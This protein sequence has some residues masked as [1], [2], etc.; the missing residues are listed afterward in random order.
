LA[1]TQ[2][3]L[4]GNFLSSKGGNHTMAEEMAEHLKTTGYS[5]IT[6]SSQ[7][8]RLFRLLDMVFTSWGRKKEYQVAYVEL[9]SGPAFLWAEAVC[10][11]LSLLKKPYILALHGGNLPIFAQRWPERVKR[12]LCKPTKVVAPSGYLVE[13]MQ[14]W[15]DEIAIIPNPIKVQL[16]PFRSRSRPMPRL[17][18]LRAFHEI[19]C[20]QMAP[21]LIAV[22][23]ATF[24]EI[25][26]TMIGPDKGDGTLQET[27]DLIHALGLDTNIE[28]IEGIPKGQVP[29]LLRQGD[30]FIN[31]SCVDNTPVSVI[32]AMACGLCV[33]STNVGG[34]PYLLEHDHDALLVPPDD[35]EVLAAAVQRILVEPGL[36]ERLSKNARC[37]AERYDWSVTIPQ[38]EKLFL[39]IV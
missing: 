19:Y 8:F 23:R 7:R 1:K 34:I 27:K 12:L 13:K 30:I 2:I 4:I 36:A 25:T 31:T 20:P 14:V 3:L 29:E 33:V 37:K 38:W 15:R 39:E 16:Y 28:I 24:P 35:P 9:Y 32:E 21:R 10:G 6:A 5:V 22:L 26:L 11:V 18:W 17:V